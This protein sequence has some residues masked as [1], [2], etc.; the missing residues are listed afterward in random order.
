MCDL[1]WPRLVTRTTVRIRQACD[2]CTGPG[3]LGFCCC[4]NER[5][6]NKAISKPFTLHAYSD[7]ESINKPLYMSLLWFPASWWRMFGTKGE[8]I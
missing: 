1:Y 3:Y 2:K 5:E 4:G 6:H 8:E 7:C